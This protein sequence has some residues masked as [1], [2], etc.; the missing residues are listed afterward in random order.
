MDK[1]RLA[2]ELYSLA[3]EILDNEESLISDEQREK[4]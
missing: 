4:K 2:E 1:S 3:Q